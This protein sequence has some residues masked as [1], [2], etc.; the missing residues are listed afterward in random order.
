MTS[1]YRRVSC[2]RPWL[3]VATMAKAMRAQAS[4]PSDMTRTPAA[5]VRPNARARRTTPPPANRRPPAGSRRHSQLRSQ[6]TNRSQHTRIP[7]SLTTLPPTTTTQC[8]L[9]TPRRCIPRLHTPLSLRLLLPRRLHMTARP[10][11]GPLRLALRPPTPLIP[12]ARLRPRRPHPPCTLR[13]IR[14]RR[15]LRTGMLRILLC[16]GLTTTPTRRRR[17]LCKRVVQLSRKYLRAT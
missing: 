16:R 10:H 17:P 5:R 8:P 4:A 9:A 14:H 15:H 11:L 7:M 2:L 6:S 13:T 12:S 1:S 3:L